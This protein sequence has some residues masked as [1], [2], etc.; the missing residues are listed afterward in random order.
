[1]I[2]ALIGDLAASTW[3]DDKQIFFSDLVGEKCMPSSYGKTL[4]QIA[5]M[6]IPNLIKGPS[7]RIAEPGTFT[8]IGQWMMINI[9]SAW[10]DK[11]IECD[12][13]I[14]SCIYF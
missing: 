14:S 3:E 6:N 10:M 1:M 13:V 7:L 4:M 5:S 8:Y 2:G 11:N 9:A 12:F